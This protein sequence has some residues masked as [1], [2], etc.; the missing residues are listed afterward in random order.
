MITPE[1]FFSLLNNRGI[2]FFTGVPDSLMKDFCTYVNENAGAGN[3]VITANEGAAIA[4]AAG[5]NL[6]TGSIAAVY[7]QNSGI[8]NSV[9]PI[10]SLADS[11]VYSIPMLLIIGWRGEPGKK[12]EPQHQKQGKVLLKLIEA[13]QMEY[14]VLGENPDEV[15][16]QIDKAL[17]HMKKYSSPYALV[18]REGTF[19]GYK[20]L[21][22]KSE[23]YSLS[24]EDAIGLLLQSLGERDIVVTTTGKASREVFE[25]RKRNGH[26][27]HR[28][29][30]T[31][32]AMGHSSQIALG[33]AISKPERLVVNLDGDGS[34][35][36][37]MGSMAVIGTKAPSNFVHVILNN[38]SHESVG[39]QPTAAFS[40]DLPKIASA[41]GYR[42]SLRAVNADELLAAMEI[43]HDSPKPVLLEIR[44]S[45]YSR[46]DLGRP[47]RSPA[48]N[49][50]DFIGF[51]R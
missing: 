50:S 21:Q 39:G 42:T 47:D 28:D 29:F 33:I 31:V 18:V 51:I 1:G 6:S 24:R 5:H 10:L 32:G 23:E 20:P 22:V 2:T 17:D 41:C 9:N 7:M 8:G 19:S 4:L 27:H 48:E 15:A 34:A 38:G 26:G 14:E 35:I 13:M 40:I 30:L 25:Y 43:I 37:H 3:H 49:K 16:A 44:L 45:G 11:E 46:A 12:D 36:M